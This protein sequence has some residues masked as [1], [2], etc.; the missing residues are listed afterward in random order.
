MISFVI[1]ACNNENRNIINKPITKTTLKD[2]STLCSFELDTFSFKGITIGNNINSVR[3]KIVYEKPERNEI[4]SNS[5]RNGRNF[6]VGNFQTYEIV[7]A[8]NISLF[9]NALKYIKVH[10]YKNKIFGIDISL[11]EDAEKLFHLE[12]IQSLFGEKFKIPSCGYIKVDNF[13]NKITVI[14]VKSKKLSI[15]T[16]F[17]ST[18]KKNKYAA[19]GTVNEFLKNLRIEITDIAT[20]KSFDTE[21]EYEFRKSKEKAKSDF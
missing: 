19:E 11:D 10:T 13:L 9:E 7:N 18:G 5:I 1:Q 2:S 16:F 14:D 4:E 12:K 3:Y 15:K 6:S 17:N 8:K 20:I 21:I